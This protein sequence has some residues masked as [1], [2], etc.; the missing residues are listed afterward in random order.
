MYWYNGALIGDNRIFLDIHDPGL[1]YGATVFTTVRVY[2]RSLDHPLTHWQDHLERLRSSLQAFDWPLPDW[3]RLRNGA[4]TLA[5]SFPV[6]RITL[7]PD[8][9][10]WIVGRSLPA[11]LQQIQQQ[12]ILGW[13]ADSPRYTRAIA[14]NKTGNY[15][16]AW[17]A[18][19]E[20]R[21]KGARE[22]ILVDRSG[23]WLETATGNLWGWKED[24]W[25]TPALESGIL[26]GIARAKLLH[27]LHEHSIPVRENLWTPDFIA[28][29][30]VL[31]YS[32]SVVEIVPF[33]RVLT[34]S[35]SLT[36]DRSGRA[37]DR[38]REYFQTG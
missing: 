22:A 2:A 19:Q 27:R 26:P 7:F 37:L 6:L 12:G 32:N 36:F 10:E 31:A 8:A 20:A 1:L 3:K 18:G 24:C 5:L 25:Y 11:D 33:D 38:V 14:D 35:S 28:G 30:S 9:R 21:Q 17:L 16:P 34:D 29:L 13:V 15:L 23:N 4:E